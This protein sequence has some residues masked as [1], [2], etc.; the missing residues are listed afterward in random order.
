MEPNK[1]C[2]FG[3]PRCLCHDCESNAAYDSCNCGYCIQCLEC[4]DKGYSVHDVYVCTG[5]KL[6][7]DGGDHDA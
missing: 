3:N 1:P 4:I 5:Y 7:D 2:P 6:R